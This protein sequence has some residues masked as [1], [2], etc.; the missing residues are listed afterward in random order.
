MKKVLVADDDETIRESLSAA[1]SYFGHKV[2]LATNGAEAI[3]VF[4][5]NPSIGIIILDLQMPVMDG[6]EA[7]I[8]FKKLKPDIEIIILSAYVEE[9]VVRELNKLGIKHIFRKPYQ[10]T[11]LLEIIDNHSDCSHLP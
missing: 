10:L 11:H 5:A 4:K 9:K 7:C 3:E 1:V 6:Q 2:Y 8:I